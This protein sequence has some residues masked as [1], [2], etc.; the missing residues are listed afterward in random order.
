[1]ERKILSVSDFPNQNLK[2]YFEYAWSQT[3][4]NDSNLT[5]SKILQVCKNLADLQLWI[6]ETSTDKA[7]IDYNP[8]NFYKKYSEIKYQCQLFFSISF[9]LL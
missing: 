8:F 1:M 3:T 2:G 9:R 6:I 7:G 5:R 4:E